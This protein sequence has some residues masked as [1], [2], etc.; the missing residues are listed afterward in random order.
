MVHL[1][2]E[3]VVLMVIKTVAVMTVLLGAVYFATFQHGYNRFFFMWKANRL[4]VPQEMRQLLEELIARYH[5]QD[6][7]KMLLNS[8]TLNK[9]LMRGISE[10]DL[11]LSLSLAEREGKQ[12]K[13]Y[14]VKRFFDRVEIGS[15]L[16]STL[17]LAVQSRITINSPHN[18][19][20]ESEVILSVNDRHG[21]KVGLPVLEK[22]M[23][24]GLNVLVGQDL[25]CLYK[26]AQGLEHFFITKV[27]AVEHG[28]EL[29]V[30][31]CAHSHKLQLVVKT[32]YP[33]KRINSEAFLSVAELA[34]D[35]TTGTRRFQVQ[36][37]SEQ[38][39]RLIDISLGQAVVRS[40]VA[41][42]VQSFVA[43]TFV[44]RGYR[45]LSYGRVVQVLAFPEYYQVHIQFVQTS[46]AVLNQMSEII[47]DL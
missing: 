14:E 30:L 8:R 6:P 33:Q 34:L 29:S 31:S 28:P 36:N 37:G 15:P 5:P 44:G 24:Q 42:P 17:E 27:K 21:F 43:L 1:L 35:K 39:G 25:E 12:F 13:Y 26:D 41:Y 2:Y 10:V 3:G 23:G 16:H 45:L 9:C 47:Y 38:T 7:Y 46:R 40:T 11:D 32:Q 22:G 20:Q 19:R 4:G 18:V